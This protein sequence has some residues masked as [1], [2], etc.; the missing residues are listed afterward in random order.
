MK[1]Y[2]INHGFLEYINIKGV[3]L[4]FKDLV[5]LNKFNQTHISKIYFENKNWLIDEHI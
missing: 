5:E 3:I 2:K 4:V 1:V